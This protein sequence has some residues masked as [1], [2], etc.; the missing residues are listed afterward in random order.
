MPSPQPSPPADPAAHGR[1][2]RLA[3]VG[4]GANLA[5]A[6]IKLAAGIIGHSYALI[7]DAVESMVDLAG[8]AIIFGG[9]R[10]AARPADED[11]PY[12]HGKAE[13]VAA[14]IVAMM[15]TAA[16]LGIAIKAVGELAAPQHTV[17]A[18]FTLWVLIIVVIVKET[19]FRL[20][21]RAGREL[22]S[23]AMHTDAWHH[24]SDA[25]TSLAAFIGIALARY[26]GY[27]E[28]DAIA[29]L[30]ASGIIIFNGI[31][32]FRTPVHELMD[33]VPEAAVDEARAVAA[34]VP[35]VILIEK[36]HGRKSG[37]RYWID[38]HV[39]VDPAMSVREAHTLSHRVKD[40]I[41]ARMPTV[42]DVL[43]HIE[44]APVRGPNS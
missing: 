37:T 38:M 13:A 36:T 28:A 12:G 29:A 41:R 4:L 24:R 33:R 17:P 6:L 39:Q 25:I 11:H 16:G 5:L 1:G 35:G 8:S 9:L 21:H 2:Q 14:L 43:V 31:A 27:H 20:A 42:A 23:G 3:L 40:E 26:G 44:P 15:V 10:I 19:L 34:A 32:L 22:G 7:A 30:I 18:A